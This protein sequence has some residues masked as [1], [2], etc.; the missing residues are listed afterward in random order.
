MSCDRLLQNQTKSVHNFITPSDFNTF[1]YVATV[2]GSDQVWHKWTTLDNKLECYY[3]QFMPQS[4][5]ISYTTSFGFDSFP[6]PD[7]KK[8]Y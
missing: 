2:V 3:L 4:K 1:E 7:R 5:R 6:E 8:T